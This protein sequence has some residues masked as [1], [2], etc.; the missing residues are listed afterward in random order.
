M[1]TRDRTR[2]I[3]MAIVGVALA[4]AWPQRATLLRLPSLMPRWRVLRWFFQKNSVFSCRPPSSLLYRFQFRRA[5]T[6]SAG[7]LPRT[8]Y[9]AP[10]RSWK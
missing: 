6:R 5:D 7:C 4:F 8:L 1:N 9:R 2:I 3:F 10:F